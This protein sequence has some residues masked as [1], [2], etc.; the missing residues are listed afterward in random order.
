MGTIN[1]FVAV[2]GTFAVLCATLNIYI[3][4]NIFGYC[5]LGLQV[6]IVLKFIDPILE[7]L[8]Q[9]HRAKRLAAEGKTLA[10]EGNQS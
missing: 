2:T 4:S 5:I 6:I 8:G 1:K 7:K 9:E 3:D 10:P